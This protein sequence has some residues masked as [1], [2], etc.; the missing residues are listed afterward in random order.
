MLLADLVAGLIIF[1]VTKMYNMAQ[2]NIVWI[3][4]WN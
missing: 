2:T 4:L 1:L 3:D